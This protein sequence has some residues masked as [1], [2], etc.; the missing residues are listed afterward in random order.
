MKKSQQRIVMWIAATALWTFLETSC[1]TV[2]GVGKDVGTVGHTI[3]R[4][5][6]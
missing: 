3:Q 2:S 5:A 1:G 4:A 6:R